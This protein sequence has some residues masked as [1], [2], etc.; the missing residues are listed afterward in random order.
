MIQKDGGQI[1]IVVKDHAQ[2]VAEKQKIIDAYRYKNNEEKYI[3][4]ALKQAVDGCNYLSLVKNDKCLNFWTSN[5][6]IRLDLPMCKHFKNEK[7]Y[8]PVLGLLAHMGFVRRSLVPYSLGPTKYNI[9]KIEVSGNI[10]TIKGYFKKWM[11]GAIEFT[12]IM[13]EEIYKTK[14]GEMKIRVG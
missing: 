11:E 5:G 4:F 6:K 3:R 8:Y 12:M 10:T 1:K 14:K 7:Y 9:Y 13:F 2:F